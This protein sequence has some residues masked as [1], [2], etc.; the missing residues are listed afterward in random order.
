MI[1]QLF[2]TATLLTLAFP[3]W[4]QTPAVQGQVISIGDGDTLRVS[5]NGKQTTIRLAC[6]DAPESSQLP[7]GPAA[8]ARLQQLA[9]IG[10]KVW[11]DAKT[12]DRYGRTIALVAN[13]KQSVNLALVQGGFAPV[14]RQYLSACPNLKAQLLAAE[15][16]A[17]KQR[18][19]FWVEPNPVMPWDYRARRV[20]PTP[21]A[22]AS[23]ANIALPGCTKTDCNCSD[24]K[25]RA[26][27]Q[28]VL[29]A[30]P[31][32]PFKLDPD[33]DGIACEGLR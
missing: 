1:K 33:R 5:I 13:D 4:A 14:Y 21:A 6:I 7:Y 17:K 25:T 29:N 24:F 16:Q 26:D 30:I 22:S 15:E 32:D 12:T 20:T 27:A 19:E 28:K 9:P 3:A 18:L 11:V 8:R 2:L 31:G 10:S 23:P